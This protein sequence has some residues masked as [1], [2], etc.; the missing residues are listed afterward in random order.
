VVQHDGGSRTKWCL[1]RGP[2]IHFEVA[3]RYRL[4]EWKKTHWSCRY[5]GNLQRRRPYWLATDAP[6]GIDEESSPGQTEKGSAGIDSARADERVHEL[7]LSGFQAPHEIDFVWGSR[8][9]ILVR[10]SLSVAITR[11]AVEAIWL[12]AVKAQCRKISAQ[13]GRISE[14]EKKPSV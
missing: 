4:I 9:C 2:F 5:P 11:A 8:S 12:G 14:L 6:L 13:R 7:R 10:K 3:V 1:H